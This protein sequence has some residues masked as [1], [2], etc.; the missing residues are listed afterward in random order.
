MAARAFFLVYYNDIY[1][2]RYSLVGGYRGDFST[3]REGNGRGGY[4]K[5]RTE[6]PLSGLHARLELLRSLVYYPC[7]PALH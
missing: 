1:E 3:I 7:Q 5:W 6:P 4:E 2:K